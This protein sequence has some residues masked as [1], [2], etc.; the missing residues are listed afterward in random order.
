MKQ[1]TVSQFLLVKIKVF[2]S[3]L[4]RFLLSE[5]LSDGKRAS[6]LQVAF[7]SFLINFFPQFRNVPAM[8]VVNG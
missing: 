5:G 2:R 8:V 1:T 7:N 6:E 4:M 3:C